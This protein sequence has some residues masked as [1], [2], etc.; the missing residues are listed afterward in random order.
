MPDLATEPRRRSDDISLDAAPAGARWRRA[1]TGDW[2]KTFAMLVTFHAVLAVVAYLFQSSYPSYPV[3]TPLDILGTRP[4]LLSHTFRWDSIHYYGILHGGYTN[5]NTPW[6]PVFYPFFPLCVGLVQAITFG[7]LGFV[8]AGFLVNFIASWLAATSLLKTVRYFV[9]STWAPWLAVIAFLSAPTAYFLHGFYTEAVFCALGFWAY[10]FAL[11]RQW[12]WMGL[13]LIPLTATRLPALLFVGLCALEF[14]RA[15]DW[16]PRRLL[17][18]NLLWFPAAFIGFG[19]YSLYLRIATGDAL[20]MFHAYTT[21]NSWPY[22]IFDPDIPRTIVRQF[23]ISVT[24]GVSAPPNNWDLVSHIIPMIALAV[25]MLSL[26]YVL[27]KHRGAGI[28]LAA[29]GLLSIVMFTLNSNVVAVHRYALPCVFVYI[30]MATAAE[31]STRLK[32][33]MYGV[34]LA[35]T[36]LMSFLYSLFIAGNWAG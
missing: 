32:H 21:S 19:A 26:G 16:K 31:H 30:A 6:L 33:L 2:A 36:V 14:F 29:F 10:L 25:L 17:N 20:K 23:E 35:H 34:I 4:T 3:G 1:L 15:Q 24:A 22:H 28:P 7:K 8:A 27:H 18:W 5:P 12:T 13:C 11:R 9:T